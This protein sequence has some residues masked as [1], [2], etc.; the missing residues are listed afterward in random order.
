MAQWGLAWCCDSAVTR[1]TSWLGLN[2]TQKETL[3]LWDVK[4]GAVGN[5]QTTDV[6]ENC[7]SLTRYWAL[8][9]PDQQEVGGGSEAEPRLGG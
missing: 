7:P 8:P 6:T 2:S 9:P 3:A 5:V 1:K 4:R